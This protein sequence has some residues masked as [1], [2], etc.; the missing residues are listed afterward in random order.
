MIG[1]PNSSGRFRMLNIALVTL[2]PEMVTAIT[3]YGITGRAVSRKLVRVRCFNPRDY[4][5]DRHHTVDDK[6]YGGGPGMVMMAEPLGKAVIDAGHWIAEQDIRP[7]KV[8]YLSPQGR[9]LDQAG[10]EY[11]GDL[12]NLILVAG[13]YEGVD[14]RFI[15]RYVDEEWSIGDYVLS[16]GELPAMV[17]IDALTRLQPGALGDADSAQQDSF[18]EGLLDHPHFTRPEIWQD[19]SVPQVLMSGHHE[20]IARWRYAQAM[21]RTFER[22]PDLLD[23]LELTEGQMQILEEFQRQ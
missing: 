9:R 7:A 10:V 8:I 5:Q 6:P 13:R 20:Q 22:R 12:G 1:T 19:L 21:K 16:G 14:E 11:L 18:S 15:Q 4:T 17:M 2:F 3:D 23:R